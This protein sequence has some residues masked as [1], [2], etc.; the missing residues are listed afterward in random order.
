MHELWSPS[1]EIKSLQQR[2]LFIIFFDVIWDPGIR[3]QDRFQY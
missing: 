3:S 2:A 1:W